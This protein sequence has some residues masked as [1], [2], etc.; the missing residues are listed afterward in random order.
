MSFSY[1]LTDL[2]TDTASGRL[3]YTRFLL[4]DTSEAN[5][6]AQDEEIAFVLTQAGNNVYSAAATLA[7]AFSVKYAKQVDTQ[8]DGQVSAKYSQASAR[9]AAVA[10][11]ME[12]LAKT[13]S[14]SL[15]MVVTGISLSDMESRRSDTDRPRGSYVG[16]FDNPY[17]DYVDE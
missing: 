11:E 6:E 7:R 9:F 12:Y 2:G 14:G 16:Q 13:K 10:N 15:S 8:V 3:N 5:A 17:G 4:G 1:D